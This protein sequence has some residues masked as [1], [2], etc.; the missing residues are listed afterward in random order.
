ML[1]ILLLSASKAVPGIPAGR[2]F[3]RHA[4]WREVMLG[5]VGGA[6]QGRALP[7]LHQ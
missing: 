7:T 6:G 1:C 4:E 2:Q 5:D 3:G